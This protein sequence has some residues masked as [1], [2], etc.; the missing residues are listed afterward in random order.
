MNFLNNLSSLFSS[1]PEE[2]WILLIGTGIFILSTLAILK[3]KKKFYHLLRVSIGSGLL[4]FLFSIAS[5][6]LKQHIGSSLVTAVS[7]IY[8]VSVGIGMFYLLAS[9]EKNKKKER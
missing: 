9:Q 6:I 3:C 2:M 4:L 1:V 7:S 5:V 8:C